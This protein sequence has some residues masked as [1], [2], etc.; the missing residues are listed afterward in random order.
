MWLNILKFKFFLVEIL[1]FWLPGRVAGPEVG[2]GRKRQGLGPALSIAS[3]ATHVYR[4]DSSADYR[5]AMKR[6]I[7]LTISHYRSQR[8][9]QRS[10][11][12][13][14]SEQLRHRV[15]QIRQWSLMRVRVQWNLVCRRSW[16]VWLTQ[17]LYMAGRII[18]TQLY[19]FLLDRW[20]L[21]CESK[22]TPTQSFCDNVGKWTNFNNSLSFTAAFENELR[23]KLLY[24]VPPHL[25]SV[26]ALPCEIWMLNRDAGVKTTFKRLDLKV[27]LSVY[28]I[29][30]NEKR[31][32][33]HYCNVGDA[34]TWYFTQ[35]MQCTKWH[36]CCYTSIN[37]CVLMS[38]INATF[39]Q[40][41]FYST[42]NCIGLPIH[43]NC[44]LAHYSGFWRISPSILNRFIYTGI[45]V[46]QKNTS[47]CIFPAS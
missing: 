37:V 7:S 10:R 5:R 40:S 38:H 36:I 8:A 20:C 47:P 26:A 11:S 45:V 13:Y 46:C 44:Q 29:K 33:L 2:P 17:S 39:L 30:R 6:D 24:N 3:A 28:Q 43:C 41:V 23:K 25:K 21:H 31:T 35:A 15:T 16:L 19:G 42:C 14:R 32:F 34:L 18:G 4:C 22:K 12:G 1:L 9:A 27:R